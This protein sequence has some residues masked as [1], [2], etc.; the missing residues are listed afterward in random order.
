MATP[1]N[2]F[3]AL[4]ARLV[5]IAFLA[6][7]FGLAVVLGTLGA[8]GLIPLDAEDP[9][10]APLL[11]SLIFGSLCLSIWLVARR[12]PLRLAYLLGPLPH[13]LA[14]LQLLWLMAGVFLFSLGAFQLSFLAL[15]LVAPG[16]VEASLQQSLL[17][18]PDQAASP[19]LYNGVML[20]SVVVV[21]PIAEEFIFRGVLLHRWGTK[22]GIGPAILLT[23]MLFGLLHAN[24]IGLFVFGVVMA[25]LYVSTRSLLVPIVAHALNNAIVSALDLLM[26]VTPPEDMTINTLAELR[27]N[28][29]LGLLCLLLSAPWVIRYILYH[30]P[31]AHTLL[32]YFANQTLGRQG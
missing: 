32:P 31:S 28:W 16:W 7:A 13:Q 26:T 8:L 22:W 12:P 20:F 10:V 24:L 21:A 17:L 11:Y 2:P 19:A 29:W 3:V 18:A 27:S 9:I 30:W 25:L 6:T 14:W 1:E 23:S 4:K 5:V 15:S